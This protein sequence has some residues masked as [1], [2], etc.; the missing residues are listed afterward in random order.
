MINFL[1]YDDLGSEATNAAQGTAVINCMYRF[2]FYLFLILVCFGRSCLL[3]AGIPIAAFIGGIGDTYAHGTFPLAMNRSIPS[4]GHYNGANDVRYFDS[5]IVLDC[6]I[7][8][9]TFIIIIC[10]HLSRLLLTG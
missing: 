2:V 5:C 8:V 3:L 9:A 10:A 1:A 4:L 7:F 6:S